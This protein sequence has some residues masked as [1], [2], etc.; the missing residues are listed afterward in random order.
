MILAR[1][2]TYLT[3]Y[4][5]QVVWDFRVYAGYVSRRGGHYI[6]TSSSSDVHKKHGTLGKLNRSDSAVHRRL[7][8]D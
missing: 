2:P 8:D 5:I 3:T 1:C 6:S 7:T 4:D